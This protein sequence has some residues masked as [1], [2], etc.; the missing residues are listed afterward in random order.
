MLDRRVLVD[1]VAEIENEWPGAELGQDLADAIVEMGAA[2]KW[3]KDFAAD[4]NTRSP[5]FYRIAIEIP[6]LLM[7]GI[8]LLVFVRPF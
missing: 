5:R 2:A 1:A 3:T 4:R 6:T 7:I 8:V